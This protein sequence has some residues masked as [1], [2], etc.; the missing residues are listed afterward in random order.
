M[1]L[2]ILLLLWLPSARMF[3]AY[4]CNTNYQGVLKFDVENIEE[5]HLGQNWISSQHEQEIQVLQKKFEEET[6]LVTCSVTRTLEVGRC[7]FNGL[8]YGRTMRPVIN[9]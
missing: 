8:V 2:P 9:Y 7:G 1:Y 4:E 5:C 6:E 3:S